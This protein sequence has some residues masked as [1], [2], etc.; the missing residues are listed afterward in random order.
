MELLDI[1]KRVVAEI[2]LNAL[3]E[4]FNRI[5]KPVCCVVKA[6]AYGHGAVSV[7]KFLESRGASY[8]A[9][10]NVEEAVE[11]RNG[12]IKAPI[13]I[14]GFTPPTCSKVLS[15]YNIDQ[16]VFSLDY[17]KELNEDAKKNNV[18][19]NIHI[20]IDTGMGRIGFQFHDN[21]N[22]LNEALASCKLSNLI[23]LG[24]FMHFAKA[25]EG[26][27]DFTLNQYNSFM[28]AVCFLEE[29]GVEFK[30][31]HCAN[32]SAIL[33]YPNYHLDMVRAGIIL[34]GINPSPLNHEVKPI[35]KLVSRVSHAKDVYEGDSISYNGLYVASKTTHIATIP[36]GYADG[37]SRELTG[38]Y[39]LI[40]GKKCKIVG[41]VCMDQIMVE[42][43][44]AKVGDEVI[45]Y[46]EGASVD[47]VASFLGTSPYKLLCD[48]GRRVP[49]VYKYNGEIVD[50]RDDLIK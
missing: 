48:I 42:S 11:L 20:K 9:V 30:L 18:N 23:P 6:D 15:D 45:I 35:M 38:W 26:V 25:D 13:L 27:N 8:F 1:Q 3:E 2:D 29:N 28:R 34:Y 46:G 16:C 4:N 19:I 40:N 43:A 10:S 17:A 32:S 36:V 5:E 22:E 47:D 14:L 7:S 49:R 12:G 24:I 37:I 31:H 21:H 44:D 33:D 50:I 41:R 39:V